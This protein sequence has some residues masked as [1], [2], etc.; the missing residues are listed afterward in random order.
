MKVT[1]VI[2]RWRCGLHLR[3]AAELVRLAQRFRSEIRLHLDS[4][5]ADARSVLSL[6]LLTAS[7]GR[8]LRVE[9]RGAD[10]HEAILAVRDF[11]HAEGRYEA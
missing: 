6:L 4:Q 3:A 10:E 2:I 11:F 9:A 5:V 7:L 8:A 1:Q